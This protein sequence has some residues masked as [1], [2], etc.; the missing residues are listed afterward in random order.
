VFQDVPEAVLLST[1]ASKSNCREVR[2]R[3]SSTTVAVHL[4]PSS[5]IKIVEQRLDH[6]SSELSF[7]ICALRTSQLSGVYRGNVRLIPDN[8]E[9]E[10]VDVPVVVWDEKIS[11]N[12]KD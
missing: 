10:A 7:S 5:N 9:R 2:V 11:R 6:S 8:D 4:I 12:Q 3:V 1:N